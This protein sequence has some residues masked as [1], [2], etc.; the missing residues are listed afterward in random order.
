L[1]PIAVPEAAVA[2][3]TLELD[4]VTVAA[5]NGP[6]RLL[7]DCISLSRLVASVWRP[8]SAD[9][10]FSNVDCCDSQLF[11]GPSGAVTA[12]LTA[13]FTSM[14][15]VAAPVAASRIW[16]RSMALDEPGNEFNAEIELME[17]ACPSKRIA[18]TSCASGF[19][20]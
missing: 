20:A 12:A 10:W 14:P 15:E 11:S 19:V 2:V 16:L 9:V 7:S 3:T 1:F 5:D 13:A 18:I 6:V 4:E 17:L 8:V